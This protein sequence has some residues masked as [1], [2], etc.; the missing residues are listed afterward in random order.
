LALRLDNAIIVQTGTVR[1]PRRE[2]P[3]GVLYGVRR[4]HWFAAWFPAL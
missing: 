3:Q 1:T 4:T 2:Q